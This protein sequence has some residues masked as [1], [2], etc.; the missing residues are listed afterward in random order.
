MKMEAVITAA[1]SSSLPESASASQTPETGDDFDDNQAA[2]SEKLSALY[3][4]PSGASQ[5]VG[6]WLRT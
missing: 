1:S 3:I 2:L 4:G 5:Y 6:A